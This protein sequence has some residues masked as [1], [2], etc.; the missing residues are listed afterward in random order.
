MRTVRSQKATVRY[1]TLIP[2]AQN[3]KGGSTGISSSHD[4]Q[5]AGIL[6]WPKNAPS[7][8]TLQLNSRA[9]QTPVQTGWAFGAESVKGE[10]RFN[11]APRAHSGFVLHFIPF[12]SRSAD[13]LYSLE[14]KR[15]RE[16]PCN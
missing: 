3:E 12:V 7:D 11:S 4:V 16:G 1:A 9:L 6:L 14:D 10:G 2:S 8:S 13:A 15:Q 5:H